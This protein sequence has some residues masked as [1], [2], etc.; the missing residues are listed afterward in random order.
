MTCIKLVAKQENIRYICSL[1]IIAIISQ[2][3]NYEVYN[4]RMYYITEIILKSLLLS[5][6]INCTTILWCELW[7]V[8]SFP[9]FPWVTEWA[10]NT[11]QSSKCCCYIS[12]SVGQEIKTMTESLFHWTGKKQKCEDGHKGAAD[13]SF[14]S[15]KKN[16]EKE[17]RVLCK[18]Q[19]ER[20]DCFSVTDENLFSQRRH[21][22]TD[23][24]VANMDA[25]MIMMEENWWI[26]I[27]QQRHHEQQYSSCLPSVPLSIPVC[28]YQWYI[29]EAR[30]WQLFVNIGGSCDSH[31]TA[32]D[33][34]A[35]HC[36]CL[37]LASEWYSL[38][39]TVPRGG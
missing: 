5:H 31:I 27:K 17:T 18:V 6:N 14:R 20:Y 35:R 25:V 13:R 19:S 38:S 12:R 28:T 32:P 23:K 16:Q 26:L 37:L 2:H 36:Q 30:D 15:E 22:H 24:T 7:R 21:R 29:I 9:Y 1:L 4:F 39:W 33:T 8:K 3:R 10:A 11:P 34:S